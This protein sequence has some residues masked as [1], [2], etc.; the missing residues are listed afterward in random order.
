MSDKCPLLLFSG[1]LDSTFMLQAALQETDVDTLYVDAG[2]HVQKVQAE[3]LAQTAILA[4]LYRRGSEGTAIAP[5]R[6]RYAFEYT[7]KNLSSAPGIMSTQ[8]PSWLIAAMYHFD[9]NLHSEVQ[10]AYVMGDDALIYRH[11]M[12][13]AWANLC[14]VSKGVAVP[15]VFP[16]MGWRKKNFLQRMPADLVDLVWVCE[17]PEWEGKTITPC[18]R[19]P[20]CKRHAREMKEHFGTPNAFRLLAKRARAASKE[21]LKA[22]PPDDIVAPEIESQTLSD[23]GSDSSRVSDAPARIPNRNKRL[24]RANPKRK[25]T[26]AKPKRPG[27]ASG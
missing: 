5:H 2:Q 19:C 12:A 21:A 16:Y 9:P 8:A 24:P 18:H 17:L 26:P 3:Q 1:G 22:L 11:E 20:A 7:A 4:W 23:G 10:I 14:L 15:L 13:A 27:S 25:L 6:V